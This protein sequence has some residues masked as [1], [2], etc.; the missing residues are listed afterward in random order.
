METR[1]EA[2]ICALDSTNPNCGPLKNGGTI[3]FPEDPDKITAR[4]T[5]YACPGCSAIAVPGYS[6]SEPI[7]P[8][9]KVMLHSTQI[10]MLLYSDTYLES[11]LMLER[12][13]CVQEQ[14]SVITPTVLNVPVLAS[15]DHEE[16]PST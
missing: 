12:R 5:E 11:G 4:A 3:V 6:G 13:D 15:K 1:A 14:Q 16:R 2:T 9:L 8:S 10:N 7:I